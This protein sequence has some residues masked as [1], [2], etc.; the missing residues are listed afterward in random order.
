MTLNYA[1]ITKIRKERLIEIDA[2][3]DLNKYKPIVILKREEFTKLVNHLDTMKTSW[4]AMKFNKSIFLFWGELVFLHSLSYA[5][6]SED[7]RSEAGASV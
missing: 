4:L 1:E 2:T 5:E 3:P 6:E 7:S